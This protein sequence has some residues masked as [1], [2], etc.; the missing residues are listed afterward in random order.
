MALLDDIQAAVLEEGSDLGPILLKVRLLAARLGSQPLADWV[1]HESEGYP[2]DSPL[3]GY[4]II[5]VSY[6]G[7][8]GCDQG[9]DT[10]VL[11][12]QMT[13]RPKT[14]SST[15]HPDARASAL[16]RRL[17]SRVRA[18]GRERWAGKQ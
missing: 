17:L 5:P 18:G 6:I 1:K 10:Q 13:A 14:P 2:A 16:V 8:N 11:R 15:A 12:P 4:R 3:P 9:S 7:S